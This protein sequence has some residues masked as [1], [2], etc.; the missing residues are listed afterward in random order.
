MEIFAPYWIQVL[1][2]WPLS[3]RALFVLSIVL[4]NWTIFLLPAWI[5]YACLESAMF[6]KYKINKDDPPPDIMA[7]CAKRTTIG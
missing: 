5:Q 3:E 4:M 7:A 6:S 2:A 1:D